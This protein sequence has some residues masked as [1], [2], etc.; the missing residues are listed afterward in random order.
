MEQV[1]LDPRVPCAVTSARFANVAFSQGSLLEG[2]L[3][4]L[5]KGQPLAVPAQTRRWF[6]TLAEAGQLCLLAAVL[7]AD[8]QVVV[9][10]L[11]PATELHDLV[12]VAERVMAELGLRPVVCHEEDEARALAADPP[13]GG[14]PLLVTRRDTAGE[15]EEEEFVAASDV[16]HPTR[17]ARLRGLT[18]PVAPPQVIDEV[19]A[20]VSRLLDDPGVPTDAAALE[21][22][23]E[24]LVPELQHQASALTLDQRM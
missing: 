23:L 4:R 3:L 21:G 12:E 9:P 22:L 11:D 24:R 2:W 19:L 7:G 14:W 1:L 10:D 17:F 6:V 16:V 20:E 5:A 13:R 8:R 15:K 18:V